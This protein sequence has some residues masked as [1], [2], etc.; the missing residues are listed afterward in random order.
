MLYFHNVGII[1]LEYIA[2]ALYMAVLSHKFQLNWQNT[3]KD[4]Q[5]IMILPQ[6]IVKRHNLRN[7][8]QKK[9]AI[10]AKHSTDVK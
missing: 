3:R 7:L 8:P 5:L 6:T 4:K 10:L 1:F 9:M 2:T